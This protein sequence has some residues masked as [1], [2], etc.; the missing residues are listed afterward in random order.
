MKL[1]SLIALSPVDKYSYHKS[2][3]VAHHN[4]Y[5][6]T[7]AYLIPYAKQLT[8]S[9]LNHIRLLRRSTQF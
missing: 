6:H 7:S 5:A 3:L 9:P 1:K 2:A 4:N 8:L